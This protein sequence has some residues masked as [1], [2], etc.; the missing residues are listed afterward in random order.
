VVFRVVFSEILVKRKT[1][2]KC[3][4]LDTPH[5][6]SHVLFVVVLL[7]LSLCCCR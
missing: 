3:F 4:I 5:V 6:R 7:S 2:K 1:R